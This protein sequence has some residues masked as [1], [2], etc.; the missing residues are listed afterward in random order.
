M[1]GLY[2]G[3]VAVADESEEERARALGAALEQVLSKLSGVASPGGPAVSAAMA[4]PQR[5]LQQFR[6]RENPGGMVALSL[7]ARFDTAAVDELMRESGLPVWS[8]QRPGVLAW[9]AVAGGDALFMAAPDAGGE[10][11]GVVDALRAGAWRRG[12]PLSFPL[13][14]LEDQVRIQPAQLWQLDDSTLEQASAR[15]TPGAILVGSGI[16]TL[17]DYARALDYLQGLDQVSGLTVREARTDVFTFQM[18]VRG[19]AT[20]LRRLASFGGVLDAE[21]ASPEDGTV[22]FRLLP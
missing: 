4:E 19:G 10:D 22:R 8:A 13:L 20:G 21:P 1:Q 18:D 2:E 17:A 14:D 6:Y 15:Y 7:W 5:Y 11:A 16:R 12:V 3:Q 9:V